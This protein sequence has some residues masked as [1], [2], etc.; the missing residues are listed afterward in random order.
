MMRDVFMNPGD[1]ADPGEI[2]A[3]KQEHAAAERQ[4]S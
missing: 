2:R 1:V 4:E 3:E